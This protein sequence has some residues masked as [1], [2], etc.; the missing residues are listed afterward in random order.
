MAEPRELMRLRLYVLNPLSLGAAAVSVWLRASFECN[1]KH[2]NLSISYLK[3]SPECRSKYKALFMKRKTAVT[4]TEF[5]SIG[6][7]CRIIIKMMIVIVNDYQ[8][9]YCA[10]KC[11]DTV[12][13]ILCT[14]CDV[15]ML[16]FSQ[17]QR[18]W[19]SWCHA[20]NRIQRQAC[21]LPTHFSVVLLTYDSLL[22]WEN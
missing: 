6:R 8:V 3:C 10:K 5:Y 11:T 21:L 13:R 2:P 18:Y 16:F 4:K 15:P 1:Q 19:H 9:R 20:A 22:N 12:F 14:G 17:I 7:Q